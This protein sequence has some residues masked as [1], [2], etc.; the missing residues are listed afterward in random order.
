M[1]K[2]G[3]TK[4]QILKEL[5]ALKKEYAELKSGYKD[6][7]KELKKK[8]KFLLKNKRRI[9][10][11]VA[12]IP[13]GIYILRSYKDG[14]Y[15]LE[16][17]SER[18]AKMF[19]S[20]PE[21][22]L[23]DF[24]LVYEA[25]HPENLESFI[26]LNI[27]GIKYRRPFNWTGRIIAKGKIQW[28]HIE[29]F[30]E[31]LKNGDILWHG[32][33]ADVTERRRTD[34]IIKNQYNQLQEMNRSKDKFF[35]VIAHDLRGPFQSLL[36]S[37][38]M[39]ATDVENLTPEQIKTFSSGLNNSLRNLYGI[40]ENLLQ[41]SMMQ[42]NMLEFDP[43]NLDLYDITNN[44]AEILNQSAAKKDIS[45]T[46]KIGR[47]TNVFADLFMLR[48]VIQNLLVNAIKF[49]KTGGQ[50]I[51]SS[52]NK[53]RFV[54]ISV[55]DNGIGMEKSKIRDLFGPSA[56]ISTRGTSGEKGTGLGL[57]L[58]KEFVERNGGEI[59]AESK[60][61]KGSKFTFTLPKAKP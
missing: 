3:R 29:S 41:W 28:L 13:V 58:C 26:D 47:K 11:L 7:L 24:S 30:P 18:A 53:G 43:E 23:A 22:L 52:L 16:Y 12:K 46:N 49:T 33:I 60:L 19:D 5:N 40:I 15:T 50:I 44:I 39:L 48:S 6:E 59:I 36:S 45:V 8:E 37:S 38:E 14:T 4:V 55:Q 31:A 42:R 9:D 1:K 56:V 17:V 51:I 27:Q 34:D 21:K 57:T 20:S 10:N 25:V 32:V 2:S 61:G 54:E 35:S